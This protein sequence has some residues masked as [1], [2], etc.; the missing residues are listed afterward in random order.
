MRLKSRITA[1]AALGL[2]AG[3]LAIGVGIGPSSAAPRPQR[4]WQAHVLY[5]SNTSGGGNADSTLR[6]AGRWG[7][8]GPPSAV[9]IQGCASAPYTTI[10]AAV[11][12]ASAGDTIAVCPGVYDEDVV[13]PV[14]KPLTI[15]GLGNPTIDA[16]HSATNTSLNNGVQ[17]L[18]S[19]TT[20][21]GFT[22]SYAEG[23]GIL[24]GACDED[25]APTTTQGWAACIADSSEPTL[26]NVT[27]RNNTVTDNDR[28][29]PTGAVLSTSTYSQCN[30]TPSP[31][32]G[33]TGPPA[34][35]GDCGEGIHLLSAVDSTI[36]DNVVTGNSG[37]ILLTD[38]N[39]PTDG[40]L[41][42]ANDVSGNAYDCGITVAGHHVGIPTLAA[43]TVTGWSTVP[44]AAGGVF[45][46]TISDNEA[47]NNGVLGQGAGVLL[48]T[49]APGG[50]VYD[51]VVEGNS[52]SGNGLAGVTVHSHSP[53]ENLN[54]N[55]IRDNT[56]GT[57]D[58]DGDFDFGGNLPLGADVDALTTGV[59][60]A[61]ATGNNP[62]TITITNN[63]IENNQNG[64]WTT[65]L[66]TG[67]FASNAFFGVTTPYA[68]P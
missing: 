49:G 24:V 12:A 36:E 54:G 45:D 22:V 14:G 1:F 42:T 56:I 46:N 59:I 60:V 63:R 21:E 30:G 40:N 52:I 43:G 61:D 68:A 66:V 17:V 62:I 5:V 31:P 41:I 11:A 13:V 34:A 7:A 37:G 32:A 44:S 65:P 10:S 38:E 20:I 67:T 3:G 48:A 39:G 35:P 4:G 6:G 57:N 51:N 9:G 26:Q 19:N 18:A 15:E 2:L 58:L 55:T 33:T 27:I 25:T 28:G 16:Y 29:N 50:A 53:G 8:L 64:I 23:E 47:T